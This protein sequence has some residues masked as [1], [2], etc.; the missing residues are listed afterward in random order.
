MSRLSHPPNRMI[1]STSSPLLCKLLANVLLN[2]CGLHGNPVFSCNLYSMIW[3]PRRFIPQMLLWPFAPAVTCLSSS[4]VRLV[5]GAF[6]CL[7]PLPHIMTVLLSQSMWLSLR[8]KSSFNLIP[9][10]A[11]KLMM[12]LSRMLSACSMRYATCSLVKLG[13][14]I[15][16]I[17]GG[18]TLVM[19][20][21][22]I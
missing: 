11:N 3:I 7:P 18:S 6:L 1:C 9:L 17:L 5:N 15:L 19:G 13:N 14:I 12:H 21:S 4:V 20:L 8:F 16:V 10:S 22:L 2:V